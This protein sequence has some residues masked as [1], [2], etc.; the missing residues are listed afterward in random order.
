MDDTALWMIKPFPEAEVVN[1]RKSSRRKAR[2]R[3]H[4]AR[5]NFSAFF[6]PQ[7]PDSARAE[8]KGGDAEAA[9]FRAPS[10]SIQH[11]QTERVDNG[12]LSQPAGALG[13][14]P[15]PKHTTSAG[16]YV[17]PGAPRLLTCRAQKQLCRLSSRGAKMNSS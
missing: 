4:G 8:T 12:P 1:F 17:L 11:Q 13:S 2:T 5:N 3:D 10:W 14:S 7:P 9:A 6:L 16:G 15:D